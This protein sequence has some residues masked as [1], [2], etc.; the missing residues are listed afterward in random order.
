[1]GT[2]RLL[3]RRVKVVTEGNVF[4][5]FIDRNEVHIGEIPEVRNLIQFGKD[6]ED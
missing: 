2:K 4:L 3:K 6:C 5:F 1:M